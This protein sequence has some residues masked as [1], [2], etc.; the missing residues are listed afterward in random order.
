MKG[1]GVLKCPTPGCGKQYKRWGEL[2]YGH[3]I[4]SFVRADKTRSHLFTHA[5]QYA[6]SSCKMPWAFQRDARRHYDSVHSSSV[7]KCPYAGCP[8]EIHRRDNLRRHML[9]C[10]WK[11]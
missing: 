10:R 5:K 4:H 7:V 9:R 8:R 3:W 2:K 11:S 6:C 1:H